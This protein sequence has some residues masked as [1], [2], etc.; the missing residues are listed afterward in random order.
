MKAAYS[1]QRLRGVVLFCALETW[2]VILS[3]T[4][5]IRKR[6]TEEETQR[7]VSAAVKIVRA[8]FRERIHYTN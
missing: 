6:N 7:L 8:E 5:G 2:Q 1:L 4:N 3:M